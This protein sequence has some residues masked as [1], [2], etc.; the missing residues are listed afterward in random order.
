MTYQNILV[1][2]SCPDEAVAERIARTL[3]EE[4]LAAC[5]NRISALRSTYRWQGRVEDEPEVL[6]LAK[7][8]GSRYEALERRISALH[9]YEVPEIVA[10]PI[11]AGSKA[12]LD[13]LTHSTD[14]AGP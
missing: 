11:V 14:H 8:S 1:L 12:Y 3:V 7:T 4:R 6:L 13:W 2:C 9:P 5:V 10:L